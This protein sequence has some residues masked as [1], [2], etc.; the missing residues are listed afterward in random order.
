[1]CRIHCLAAGLVVLLGLVVGTTACI[2]KETPSVDQ[3]SASESPSATPLS[4]ATMA[5]ALTTGP[6]GE[7]I[8]VT[9]AAVTSAATGL[10]TQTSTPPP[11]TALLPTLTAEEEVEF[12]S[13]LMLPKDSCPL[14]CWWDI[15]PGETTIEEAQAT[16]SGIGADRWESDLNDAYRELRLGQKDRHGFLHPDQ[17][18]LRLYHEDGIV[19]ALHLSSWRFA[20]PDQGLFDEQ[21]ESLGVASI[22]EKFGMPSEVHLL[23]SPNPAA[24]MYELILT[25]NDRHLQIDYLAPHR[26]FGEGNGGVCFRVG[27]L[28]AV[29]VAAVSPN[30][31][32]SDYSLTT[33]G[34]FVVPSWQEATATSLQEFYEIFRDDPEACIA[35]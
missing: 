18:L 6:D 1:M 30:P 24:V 21:W 33:R 25:Y 15:V 7:S 22:L 9:A 32:L 14:P 11:T 34:E 26:Q 10:S 20:F 13:K 27:D 3:H 19:T 12:V 29:Q 31:V 5:E 4:A 16:L 23:L 17:M 8:P 35:R 28:E 2:P